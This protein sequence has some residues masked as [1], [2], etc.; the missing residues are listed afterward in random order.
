MY[1]KYCLW[2]HGR[3]NLDG[4]FWFISWFHGLPIF[5]YPCIC[6]G[7]FQCPASLGHP[8]FSPIMMAPRLV[9]NNYSP[10]LWRSGAQA[11][12]VAKSERSWRDQRAEASVLRWQCSVFKSCVGKH[13]SPARFPGTDQE[14]LHI[15]PRVCLTVVNCYF[16]SVGQGECRPESFHHSA[17]V[18]IADTAGFSM[19]IIDKSY[20]CK[21][22]TCTQ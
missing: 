22:A 1:F 7:S 12:S 2:G 5:L 4:T 9:L 8:G 15:K 3:V 6:Y 21:Y 20:S 19:R 14:C 18:H 16:N 17:L 13:S 11:R 10:V